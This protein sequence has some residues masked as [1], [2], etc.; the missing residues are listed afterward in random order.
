M[1]L[2]EISVDSNAHLTAVDPGGT[3]LAD[4]DLTPA[5]DA[6][7]L[8]GTG[9]MDPSH[10]NGIFTYRRA[11]GGGYQDVFVIFTIKGMLF[12][13]FSPHTSDGG[14]APYDYFYGAALM[15]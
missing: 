1:A 11:A 10:C 3:L 7:Y 8:T 13:S 14:D 2:A 6:A 9:R 5:G 4:N 12:A 15:R